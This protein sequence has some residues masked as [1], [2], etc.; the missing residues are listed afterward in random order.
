[1]STANDAAGATVMVNISGS[2]GGESE[3]ECV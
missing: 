3:C 1:M 2:P